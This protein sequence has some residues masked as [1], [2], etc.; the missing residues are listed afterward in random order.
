MIEILLISSLLGLCLILWLFYHGIVY[1]SRDADD[2]AATDT[3]KIL[4]RKSFL[5]DHVAIHVPA[6]LSAHEKQIHALKIKLSK[7]ISGMTFPGKLEDDSHLSKSF[8]VDY[9]QPRA[10]LSELLVQDVKRVL[11]IDENPLC[12]VYQ[13]ALVSNLASHEKPGYLPLEIVRYDIEPASFRVLKSMD[14]QALSVEINHLYDAELQEVNAYNAK[15]ESLL[16]LVHE[17]NAAINNVNKKIDET[18]KQYS[19]EYAQEKRFIEDLLRSYKAGLKDGVEDYFGLVF[20]SMTWPNSLPYDWVVQ[21]DAEKSILIAEV[22]LPDVVN[23]PLKKWV[24]QKSET[25]I[26]PLNKEEKNTFVPT[27]HPAILLRVAYELLRNDSDKKIEL[28]VINGWVEFHDPQTGILTKSYVS[29]LSVKHEEVMSLVLE[30]LDPLAAFNKL[31][32]L[33]ASTLSEIIPIQPELMVGLQD[34]MLAEVGV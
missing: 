5:K 34:F 11:K 3:Q 31:R 29:S 8:F 25:V 20:S 32:G 23:E 15:R 10:A 2:K 16:S 6:D 12:N 19:L 1:L 9:N 24:D 21:F 4:R 14:N 18:A 30:K 26:A 17:V 33:S 7:K 22:Q 27:V 28:L 13:K